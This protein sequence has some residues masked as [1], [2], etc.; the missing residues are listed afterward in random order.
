MAGFKR[1]IVGLTPPLVLAAAR[2][3]VKAPAAPVAEPVMPS[4]ASDRVEAFGQYGE[5]LIID[6]VLGCSATGFYVDI[7]ANDPVVFSNTQRFHRR[8]WRGVCVEPHPGLCERLRLDRSG[9]L[10]LNAGVGAGDA[11]MPFYRIDPDTLSTFDRELADRNVAENEGA[12]VVEVLTI[13]VVTLKTLFSKHVPPGKQL[14]FMSVDVEG[15]ELA[16]LGGNDWGTWRP[17]LVMAEIN[18][19]GPRI[20]E[21]MDGVGYDYVWSNGTNGLFRDRR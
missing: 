20:V 16:A 17:T 7:G 5:D 8:G 1:L 2:R 12:R 10:V 21:F 19:G 6:A 9:D 14:D 11:T 18:R 4:F 3:V 13:E 15:G